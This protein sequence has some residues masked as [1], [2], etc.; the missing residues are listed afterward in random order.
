MADRI[1]DEREVAQII[2]RAAERQADAAPAPEVGLTL[3]ELERLAREAGIDP[4]HVREAAAEVAAGRSSGGAR[5]TATQVAAERWIE[6]PL[7]ESAWEDVLDRLRDRFGAD[8]GHWFGRGGS[9]TS[10]VGRTREWVHT[11][12]LGVYTHVVLSDRGD[13]L[14]LRLSQVV[15]VARSEVEGPLWG[16]VL[17]LILAWPMATALLG[18]GSGELMAAILGLAFAVLSVAVYAAD[19]AWRARKQRALT[20]LADELAGV[21]AGG[22]GAATTEREHRPS[23]GGQLELDD[24]DDLAAPTRSGDTGR[25]SR[26]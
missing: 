23:S 10:Q 22:P 3:G 24:L 15:G 4:R 8:A 26:T 19:R 13:R 21:L 12:G 7:D 17:T 25:R 5:Q 11:S 9:G 14:R 16:A 1:F 18:A 2:E 6:A 20:E